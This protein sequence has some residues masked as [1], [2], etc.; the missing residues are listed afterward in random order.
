MELR[1]HK[2]LTSCTR[3]SVHS[4]QTVDSK[5]EELEMEEVNEVRFREKLAQ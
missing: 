5:V 2:E 1:T 4:E 3:S